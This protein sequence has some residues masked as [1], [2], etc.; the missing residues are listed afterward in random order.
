MKIK[1]N[2]VGW[3][4]WIVRLARREPVVGAVIEPFRCLKSESLNCKSRISN[5]ESDGVTRR[6]KSGGR[7]L[8]GLDT[9]RQLPIT[10][11]QSQIGNRQSQIPRFP[12]DMLSNPG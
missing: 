6:A 12:I 8:R 9:T 2:G 10:D 1:E 5:R 3:K 11:R 4:F 7:K